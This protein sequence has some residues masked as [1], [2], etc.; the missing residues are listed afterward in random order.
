MGA[1][2]ESMVIEEILRALNAV[3]INYS[4][5][6]YR[7]SGGAEIDLLLEGKFGLIPFEKKH[8]QTVNSRHLR[9]VRDFINEHHCSFGII[10]YNDEKVRQYEEKIFGIPFSILPS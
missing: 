10:I 4:P 5:Y 1:R 2:W 9:S 3:E 7:T 6:Y 8:T